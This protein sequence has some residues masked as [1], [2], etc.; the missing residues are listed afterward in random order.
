MESDF[1]LYIYSNFWFHLKLFPSFFL[2]RDPA[3]TEFSPPGAKEARL[4]KNYLQAWLVC[5]T[6]PWF[7]GH[8]GLKQHKAEQYHWE[9]SEAKEIGHPTELYK[10]EVMDVHKIK[11]DDY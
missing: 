4:M 11:G 1:Q 8:Q 9:W 5:Q 10:G 6:K 3:K 7:V 2:V